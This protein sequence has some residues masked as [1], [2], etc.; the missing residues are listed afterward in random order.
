MPDV[1]P[2]IRIT[3]VT[4]IEAITS[5]VRSIPER[6]FGVL[7][8]TDRKQSDAVVGVM[9]GSERVV[10]GAE[11]D[12][13]FM[14]GIDMW[15]NLAKQGETNGRVEYFANLGLSDGKLLPDN[16]IREGWELLSPLGV[17]PQS[18]EG[19]VGTI[20]T[21]PNATFFSTLDLVT[22]LLSKDTVMA[23]VN[24]TGDVNLLVKTDNIPL[25][26][27][28]AAAE[29]Y[30]YERLEDISRRLRVESEDEVRERIVKQIDFILDTA[31]KLGII[32]AR[33]RKESAGFRVIR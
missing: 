9:G 12:S 24:S 26:E 33:K 14:L 22:F 5:A 30:A 18:T 7:T 4:K 29:E 15:E 11:I 28:R 25:D 21:H 6:L 10:H 23:M 16:D 3:P 32:V 20:H 19:R 8:P 31:K 17:L 27:K 1:S 13:E 2:E